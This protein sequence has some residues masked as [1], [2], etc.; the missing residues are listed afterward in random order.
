MSRSVKNLTRKYD[1]AN[2]GPLSPTRR[3]RSFTTSCPSPFDK[4]SPA[5]RFNNHLKG[6]CNTKIGNDIGQTDIYFL[7]ITYHVDI[8]EAKKIQSET[9][10]VQGVTKKDW[11]SDDDFEELAHVLKLVSSNDVQNIFT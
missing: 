4:P 10:D 5:P 3:G 1:D 9:G 11:L 8:Q 6:Q 2:D 7:R